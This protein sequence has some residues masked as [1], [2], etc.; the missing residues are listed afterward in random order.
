ME[1]IWDVTNRNFG[2]FLLSKPLVVLYF[3]ADWY[4]GDGY[5]KYRIK[6]LA[7]KYPKVSFGCMDIDRPNSHN[8]VTCLG[9]KMNPSVGFFCKGAKHN[10]LA[11]PSSL[12]VLSKAVEEAM[13][14]AER[15]HRLRLKY[16]LA[17]SKGN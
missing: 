1:S 9:V 11:G 16:S 7:K 4:S 12:L 17:Q 13:I 10:I 14:V 15:R 3:W 2:D 8:M 6:Q 5:M